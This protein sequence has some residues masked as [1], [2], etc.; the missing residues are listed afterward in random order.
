MALDKETLREVAEFLYKKP[1]DLEEGQDPMAV[2]GDLH[3]AHADA[4]QG[5]GQDKYNHGFKNGAIELEKKLRGSFEVEE[6]LQGEDLIKYLK[7][8]FEK[9]SA[10]KE[11]LEKI[12]SDYNAKLEAIQ[13]QKAESADEW[14]TKYDTLMDELA[15]KN[16]AI[17]F[18]NAL[19]PFLADKSLNLSED[20]A[21]NKIKI[22]A[23]KTQLSKHNL[24]ITE[25]GVQ[26]LGSD[27][28]QLLD[29]MGRMVTFDELAKQYLTALIGYKGAQNPSFKSSDVMTVDALKKWLDENG[30]LSNTEEYK[31]KRREYVNII[32]KT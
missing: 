20:N 3:K 5:N 6:G 21:V 12:K 1:V 17:K 31:R 8:S 9:K 13:K 25:N 19:N 10:S 24:N 30:N 22:D 18:N 15:A 11:E 26:V 29:G 28:T 7:D 27:G 32:R 23:V 4:L 14:K 2:L 16:K